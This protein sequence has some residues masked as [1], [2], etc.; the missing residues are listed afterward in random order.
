MPQTFHIKD[1]SI[2]ALATGRRAQN[3][4]E[5]RDHVRTVDAAC[6]YYHFWGSRLLPRFDDPEYNND[7]AAWCRHALQDDIMAERLA[8][9][10]GGEVIEGGVKAKFITRT[11]DDALSYF[12]TN[13]WLDPYRIG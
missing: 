7:F 8:V 9:V 10:D 13:P 3:L 12:F 11:G 4:R 6:I 1:C 5:L 2:A